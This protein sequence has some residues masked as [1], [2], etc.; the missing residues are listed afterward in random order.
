MCLFLF[1]YWSQVQKGELVSCLYLLICEEMEER[2][3]KEMSIR[4]PSSFK[5]KVNIYN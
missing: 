1:K 3:C 4:I 2:I 5:K